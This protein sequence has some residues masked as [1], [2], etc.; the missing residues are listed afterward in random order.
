LAEKCNKIS[1]MQQQFNRGEPPLKDGRLVI[2]PYVIKPHSYQPNVDQQEL[3]TACQPICDTVHRLFPNTRFI[4]G[5]IATLPPGVKLGWHV[6]PMW[7]HEHCHRI[8]VPIITDVSC[9]QLWNGHEQHLDI[10]K[11]YEINNRVRHS[12]HNSSDIF[13]IH[14]ILDLCDNTTW[15][16]FVQKGGNPNAMTCDPQL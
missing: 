1:W 2:L 11:I 14:V 5:E 3:I 16:E 7:F 4:R 13:R 6:D 10:G 9:V 15:M 12:A 8:H